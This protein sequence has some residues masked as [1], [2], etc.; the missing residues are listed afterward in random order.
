MRSSLNRFHL[1]LVLCLLVWGCGPSESEKRKKALDERKKEEKRLL[2]EKERKRKEE[3]ERAVALEE[4]RLRKEEATEAMRGLLADVRRD[5]EWGHLGGVE[6]T[7]ER[8]L[9]DDVIDAAER[10]SDTDRATLIA[11]REEVVEEVRKAITE[12]L[13]PFREEVRLGEEHPKVVSRI[14]EKLG[15]T[16]L[17]SEW[18]K[19]LE[20]FQEQWAGSACIVTDSG[21]ASNYLGA[22]YRALGEKLG[23]MPIVPSNHLLEDGPGVGRLRIEV[24]AKL[25][26][27]EYYGLYKFIDYNAEFELEVTTPNGKSN[28]DGLHRMIG[29][30][31]E[32]PDSIRGDLFDAVKAEHEIR[33]AEGLESGIK[34]LPALEFE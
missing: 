6:L 34:R 24:G 32:P 20:S 14:L 12:G 11:W 8:L 29:V 4:A 25:K 17:L 5:L 23:S 10:N 15:L 19:E 3:E 1:G 7:I 16:E 28:W 13:A 30:S 26:S 21:S 33:L 9:K 31:W 22:L 18:E 27:K 2:L